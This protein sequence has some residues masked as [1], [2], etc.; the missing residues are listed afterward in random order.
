MWLRAQAPLPAAPLVTQLAA[1]G[2]T[3]LPTAAASGQGDSYVVPRPR[4]AAVM[5][6]STEL[7]NY[8]VAQPWLRWSPRSSTFCYT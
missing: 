5:V 2:Q 1:P 3:T 6:P 8:V 4:P 7:A